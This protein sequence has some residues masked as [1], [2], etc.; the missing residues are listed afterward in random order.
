M[1]TLTITISLLGRQVLSATAECD[2]EP[3]Q[4]KAPEASRENGVLYYQIGTGGNGSNRQIPE[5][6]VCW[7][8]GGGG[9]GGFCP[10]A[11]KPPLQWVTEP[12]ADYV[13]PQYPEGRTAWEQT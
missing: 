4:G 7:A 9:H 13:R 5:C 1:R 10:N 3:G 12:P 2:D 11:G 8:R 6:P